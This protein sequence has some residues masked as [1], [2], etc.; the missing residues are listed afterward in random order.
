MG[1]GMP[2]EFTAKAAKKKYH[3]S[4]PSALSAVRARYSFARVG[5][6]LLIIILFRLFVKTEILSS[7]GKSSVL[8]R[9][10]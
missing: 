2:P 4:A 10:L 1:T 9:Y 6:A 3:I 7:L 8:N 5:L